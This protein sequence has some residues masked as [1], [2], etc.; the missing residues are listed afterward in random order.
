MIS[1]L[2][3]EL[4]SCGQRALFTGVRALGMVTEL[5]NSG[6]SVKSRKIH[7]NTKNTA[8]FCRNLIKYTSVQHYLKLTSAIGA[9]YLP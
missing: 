6:K 9:I 8:K 2:V 1:F 4:K 3:F 5:R 7:K